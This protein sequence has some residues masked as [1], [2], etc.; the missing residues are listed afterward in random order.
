MIEDG[1]VFQHKGENNDFS[2]YPSQMIQVQKSF[3][4]KQPIL[5]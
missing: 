4:I 2:S 1:I 3:G 5:V